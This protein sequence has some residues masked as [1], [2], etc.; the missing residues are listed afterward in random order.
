MNKQN[1]VIAG[2]VNI[3]AKEGIPSNELITIAITINYTHLRMLNYL[4]D[5]AKK[6]ITEDAESAL[7]KV[8]SGYELARI[9]DDTAG[10]R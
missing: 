4:D 10:H 5:V 2:I 9:H 8:R 3:L 6:M 7:T 1:R